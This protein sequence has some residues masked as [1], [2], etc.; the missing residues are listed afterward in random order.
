MGG[1]NV[2]SSFHVIGEILDRVYPEGASEPRTNVQTTLVPAGGA[3]MAELKLQEPGSYTLVDHSLGRLQKGAAG[4]LQV[5]GEA[6]PDVFQ[7]LQVGH[8]G[9]SGH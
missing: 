8:G 9:D 6:D 7:P 3:M 2:T 1:P 5:E 4:V